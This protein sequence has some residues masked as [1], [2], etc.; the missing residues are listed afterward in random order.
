MPADVLVPLPFINLPAQT[1]RVRAGVETA[2]QKVIDHGQFVM[3]PEVYTLEEQLSQFC[4]AC[5]V[6]SCS[7]GTDALYLA[8]R[9]HG[10]KA[11]DAI[12]VPTFTFAATAEVVVNIGA[13][14]IFVDCEDRFFCMDS[15]SIKVGIKRAKE[16]GI[17]LVGI[18]AADLFGQ[19]ADYPTIH[20]IAESEGLW[21]VADAAQSF[22]ATQGQRP[23]GTL[24]SI[25]TTS[26]F[27]AKPLGCWGDGG[28]IFTDDL[29]FA[30][31]MKSLRI[32]GHGKDRY[33]NIRSGIN[34]RLDTIQAAILL[35]KLKIFPDE[36]RARNA[37]ATQYAE[38]LSDLVDVP[39][40]APNAT[41]VWAQYVV[42]LPDA[43]NRKDVMAFLKARGIPSCVYYE[44]PLHRQKAFSAYPTASALVCAE[45]LCQRVLA[46]PMDAYLS[47]ADVDRVGSA[48]RQA[49]LT[50]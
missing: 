2:I 43:V 16:L 18:I 19:P 12:L 7:N 36:I 50:A 21:V 25:S 37:V 45:S 11:G 26:F 15:D 4:G 47:T 42:V 46:L 23:V 20:A 3:G 41:S 10:V 17:P 8:L 34:A 48:L 40:I 14:P 22:G 24:A 32:H 30:D 39:R 29:A 44:R 5:Y 9:A 35:E 13:I 28:A 31:I 49:L 33:E 27:P 6:L 1:A 38:H